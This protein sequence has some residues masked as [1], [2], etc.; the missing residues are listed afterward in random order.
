MFVQTATREPATRIPAE[1]VA[2]DRSSRRRKSR[3]WLRRH[4]DGFVAEWRV[5]AIIFVFTGVWVL[6]GLAIINGMSTSG[7][8][9]GGGV[10]GLMDQLKRGRPAE[11][12][13]SEERKQL[14]DFKESQGK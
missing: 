12:L 1:P 14:Q 4:W 7:H 9:T 8:S 5:L 2:G 3:G 11:S 10:F 13:T 6:L